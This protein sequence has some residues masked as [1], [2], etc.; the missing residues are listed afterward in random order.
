[1]DA[2]TTP[3]PQVADLI[4]TGR[5]RVAL[6]PPEYNR[7]PVTGELRGWAVDLGGAL[8]A[9]LGVEP[10]PVEYPSPRQILEDLKAGACDVAFLTID[11]SGLAEV[12]VSPPFIQFDYTYLVPAGSFIRSVADADRPGGRIAVVRNHASTLALSRILKHAELV[13]AESPESALDLLRTGHADAFASIRPALLEY[14][15]KLPGSRVLEDGYGANLLAMV[16]PNGHAGWLAYIG[17]F[18]EEAKASGLVQRVIERGGWRGVQLAPPEFPTSRSEWV[19]HGRATRSDAHW[20]PFRVL[21]AESAPNMALEATD[22]SVGFFSSLGVRA[23]A[24]AL[25]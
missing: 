10:L 12:G 13:G 20:P 16:V 8:G 18:I 14:V 9:C 22:H 24:C 5:V 11:P 2:R 1:M 19:C 23:V 17:K 15:P 7:D 4:R 6:F 21:L 25:A 3:D